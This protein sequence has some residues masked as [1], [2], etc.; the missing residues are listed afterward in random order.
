MEKY[1]RSISKIKRILRL[2]PR[3]EDFRSTILKRMPLSSVCAEIGV[4]KGDFSM[5]IREFILPQELHLIDTWEY[6]DEFEFPSV[7]YNRSIPKNQSDMDCIYEGVR[8]RFDKFDDI[9]I[10]RG[11]SAEILHTFKDA[12]FDWV[13]IDGNHNYEYIRRDLSDCF[14]KVKAEGIIAGD[15]YSDE[16]PSVKVAVHDFIREN[17]LKD[18]QLW[19]FG[20][21]FMIKL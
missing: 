12:Y 21:Q 4:W 13:Y 16:F 2:E 18:N 10:H 20:S 11:K 19:V 9:I 15:D 14:L 3:K 5:R 17:H 8:K 1:R 6:R 7:W